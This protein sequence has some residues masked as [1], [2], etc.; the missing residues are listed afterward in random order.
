MS[1]CFPK[2]FREDH[3]HLT[4][5]CEL[6]TCDLDQNIRALHPGPSGIIAVPCPAPVKAGFLWAELGQKKR[7]TMVGHG[8]VRQDR[9][10]VGVLVHLRW[11]DRVIEEPGDMRERSLADMTAQPGCSQF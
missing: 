4:P 8:V 5:S 1:S 3:M 2:P 10:I 7:S 11:Q 6:F 9:M